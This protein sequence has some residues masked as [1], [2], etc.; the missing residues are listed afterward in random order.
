M[1]IS[2]RQRAS[3]KHA[4]YPT[5]SITLASLVQ[6]G[7]CTIRTRDAI[8]S[9]PIHPACPQWAHGKDSLSLTLFKSRPVSSMELACRHKLEI[10]DLQG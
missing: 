10:A 1:M 5:L 8:D 2:S 4:N 9:P 6:D 3:A 7:G